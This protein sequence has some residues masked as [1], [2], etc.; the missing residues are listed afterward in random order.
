MT[1][2]GHGNGKSE[3][4]RVP[5]RDVRVL[6]KRF[7][8][9]VTTDGDSA[10]GFRVLL[11]GRGA[12]TPKKT[13]LVLPTQALADAI[14]AE[15][16]RQAVHIN[17]ADMPLTRLANTAIDGVSGREAEVAA[18]IAKYAGTDL[19]CYRA[20]FPPGLVKRQTEL[21]DPPLRRADTRLG[22]AFRVTT[23]LMHVAQE[24]AVT[25]AVLEALRDRPAMTLTG[26]HV[27]TS[28]TGS[29]VLALAVFEHHL[30]PA[31]AWV[32]AHVDEDWQIGLWGTDAEATARRAERWVEMDAAGRWLT[33]L[34]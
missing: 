10:S 16:R 17:P 2:N 19:L 5:G 1:G 31:E 12:R 20:E 25:E 4:I 22:V 28:L 8:K 15:W 13:P 9:G 29:A 24:P 30:T 26:L 33:L 18:D 3:P 14:A 34:L 27:L 21:W 6:P 32:A 11:D 7:Y 23:G